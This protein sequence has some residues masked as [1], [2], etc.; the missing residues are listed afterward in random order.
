M[1]GHSWGSPWRRGHPV[2]S[3]PTPRSRGRAGVRKSTHPQRTEILASSGVFR[4]KA[5][6]L[7]FLTPDTLHADLV[8]GSYPPVKSLGGVVHKMGPGCIH[9]CIFSACS[10]IDPLCW[11]V[12]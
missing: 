11:L 10:I 2:I 12:E 8:W 5:L 1:P 7:S 3:P 9:S 6:A 4:I